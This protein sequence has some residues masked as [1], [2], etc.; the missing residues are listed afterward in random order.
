MTGRQRL[1]NLKLYDY[2]NRLY[3]PELGRFMQPDP[4]EFAAGDYN[5]YRYCHNDPV[6][7]SDPFGLFVYLFEPSFT[8]SDQS[9]F[10]KVINLL[11]DKSAHFRQMDASHKNWLVRIA[12]TDAKNNTGFHLHADHLKYLHLNPTSSRYLDTAT[13]KTIASY[14]GQLPPG[15]LEGQ[16]ITFGHELGHRIGEVDEGGKNA[17]GSPGRNV[18]KNENP[19]RTD[20]L[21]K[22]HDREHYLGEVVRVWHDGHDK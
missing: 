1:S 6:N 5:L 16:A 9:H 22:G 2:R 10:W 18:E 14:P 17:D 13:Y 15:G 3:N 21:G 4:K 19:I 12:A 8:A 11:Q 20:L 7:K